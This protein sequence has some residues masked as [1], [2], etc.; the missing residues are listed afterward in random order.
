M[1]LTNISLILH[2]EVNEW[3]YDNLGVMVM[4]SA[5]VYGIDYHIAGN[6]GEH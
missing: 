4:S 3:S 1:S 6:F 5:F 2:E